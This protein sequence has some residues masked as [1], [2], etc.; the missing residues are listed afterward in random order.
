[1]ADSLYAREVRTASIREYRDYVADF[2]KL[3]RSG[4]TLSAVSGTDS[5]GTT[6]GVTESTGHV[7]IASGGSAPAINGSTLTLEDGSTIATGKAV[8]FWARADGATVGNE[9]EIRV[10]AQTSGG[11]TRELRC[12][13]AVA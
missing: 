8:Q 7:T 11:R 1:M 3:L 6:L 4:E 13:L 9:Y 2:T 12:R 10:V 5:Q